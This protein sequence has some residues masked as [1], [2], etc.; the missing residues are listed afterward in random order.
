MFEWIGLHDY[1]HESNGTTPTRGANVTSADAAI[2]YRTLGR[3]D[4]DR[5]DRVEVHASRYPSPQPTPNA[6]AHAVRR[7]RYEDLWGS[8]VRTDLLELE[9]LFVEPIYQMLRQQM[10][11]HEMEQAGELGAD[12]VRARLRR[13]R[14]EHRSCGRRSRR[15][16]SRR[17]NPP[18]TPD[19]SPTSAT[20]GTHSASTPSGS[21][22]STPRPSS[23][24][25]APTSDEFKD[26]YR[27][28][29]PTHAMANSE[30]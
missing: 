8:V 10:L 23:R 17:F 13:A 1:L 22:G 4:R 27:H 25:A 12:R 18:P 24:S 30:E 6:A 21:S 19:T 28:L 5:T 7:G 14:G 16:R 29:D 26:R 15:R 20:S 9:D 11:A 2:R 3:R